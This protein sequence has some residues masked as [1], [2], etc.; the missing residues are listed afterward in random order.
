[1]YSY[2]CQKNKNFLHLN[3][4][5]GQNGSVPLDLPPSTSDSPTLLLK[6]SSHVSSAFPNPFKTQQFAS[7]RYF[8]LYQSMYSAH[9]HSPSFHSVEA[10]TL[11]APQSPVLCSY[12]D[13]YC[14]LYI[15]RLGWIK[16]FYRF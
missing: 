14:L 3:P 5:S 8:F 11:L 2:S 6:H 9:S 10:V 15:A 7:P 13:K 12:T 4:S 16:H 1:M